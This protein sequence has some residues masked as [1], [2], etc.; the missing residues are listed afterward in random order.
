M[1]KG[2]MRV[3][4]CRRS[5]SLAMLGLLI[6]LLA[7]SLG[8]VAPQSV[9]AHASLVESVPVSGARLS[10]SPPEIKITFNEELDSGLYYIKVYDNNGKE[11]TSNKAHMNEQGNGIAIGLPKLEDGVYLISYHIISADGHP[12]GGSYPFTVGN[13]PESDELS[14]SPALHNHDHGSGPLT[15]KGLLQYASRGLWFLT[16]LVLTGWM[17]WLRMPAAKGLLAN[18]TLSAWTLNLQ[19]GHLVALLLLIF[20]HIEDLLG[21]GGV[22]ELWQLISA[23]TIGISWVLLLALSLAGFLLVGRRLWLDV[24]WAIALLAAKSFSGHAASFSPKWLT[25]GLDF[26]HL[27]ASACWAGGLVL[28]F[29]L[30]RKKDDKLGDYMR[31]FSRMAFISIVVLTVS[32]VL[33]V[34]LFLPNLHYLLYTTWGKLLLVKVGVVVLVA[35]V[36][37]VI[38]LFLRKG[39]IQQTHI[40]VKLDLSLM[41][42]I[43]ALV[44]LITYMAPIPSNQPFTWHQMG[45]KVHV[46]VDI[47]PK[48]PGTN[49]FEAS[50]WLPKNLGKP[51]QVL[52]ILHNQDDETI[53]PISVPLEPYVDS[54]QLQVDGYGTDLAKYDYKGQGAFLPFRG[55]WQVEMRVMDSDDNETVYTRDF[56]VY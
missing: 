49:T 38:R 46:S 26:V 16:L 53:S 8:T 12:V 11:I 13:P 43:V 22:E 32:G 30:W 47:S 39:G 34:L 21:G 23:T 42:V 18:G 27:A 2:I 51:K 24:V 9:S 17:L 5:L 10:Q 25:I 40:W 7:V 55:N 41:V 44:G 4:G 15:T 6:M 33:S 19:R 36:G 45:E 29:V 35:V 14:S 54:V 28:L 56:I 48:V 31:S 1:N 52:M 50:V 37:F 20:T 3:K